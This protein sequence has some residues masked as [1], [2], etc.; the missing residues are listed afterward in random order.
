MGVKLAVWV[1]L[2][3]GRKTIIDGLLST[4]YYNA[5]IIECL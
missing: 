2:V 4:D 3:G 1:A 5:D